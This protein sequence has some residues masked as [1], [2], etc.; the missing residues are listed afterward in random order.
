[1]EENVMID[2]ERSVTSTHNDS[3]SFPILIKSAFQLRFY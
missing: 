3:N 1:V 2:D